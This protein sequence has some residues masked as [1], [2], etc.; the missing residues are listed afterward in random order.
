LYEQETAVVELDLG[1]PREARF[2]GRDVDRPSGRVLAEQGSLRPAQHLDPI[3]VEEIERRRGGTGV[4]DAVDVET[5]ARLE[6]VIG[7]SEGRAQPADVD[8]EL[9]IGR[10]ELTVGSSPSGDSR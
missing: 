1:A 10:V 4:K 2:A 5:D 3:D 7:K 9:G 8:D 6:A